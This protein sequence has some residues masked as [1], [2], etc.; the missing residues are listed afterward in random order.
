MRVAVIGGTG[1][2]GSEV[3]R[4]LSPSNQVLVCARTTGDYVVDIT[5]SATIERL[6]KAIG[7]VDAVVCTA[8]EAMFKPFGDM[9]SDDFGVGIDSK[10]MGQV[11]VVRIGLNYVRDGGSFTLTSGVTARNPI[12]ACV[13]Y[14]LVNAALEGFVRGAALDLPRSVRLNAVSPQWVD[15][16]LRSYGMDPTWGVPVELVARGYVESVEGTLTGTVI[17][18][19]WHDDRPPVSIGV[20][21]VAGSHA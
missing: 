7:T 18:A 8:G 17:D 4:Q 16:S 9:S 2:I 1:T 21:A 10:L 13:G 15:V 14:S 3:V 12:P 11:D 6:F 5:R 20:P 19:G